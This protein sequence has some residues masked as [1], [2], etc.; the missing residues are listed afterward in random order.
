MGRGNDL[1]RLL[2]FIRRSTEGTDLQR[3]THLKT[4]NPDVWESLQYAAEL[5]SPIDSEMRRACIELLERRPPNH[6]RIA[7]KRGED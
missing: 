7:R 1:I 3:A 2:D 5:D 6:E 4:M